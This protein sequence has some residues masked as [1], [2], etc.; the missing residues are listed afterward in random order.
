MGEKVRQPWLRDV[1]ANAHFQR[2]VASCSRTNQWE[3]R[4]TLTLKKGKFRFLVSL[5]SRSATSVSVFFFSKSVRCLGKDRSLFSGDQWSARTKHNPTEAG[6]RTV[7]RTKIKKHL[8]QGTSFAI[9]KQ[10]FG[11]KFKNPKSFMLSKNSLILTF[12]YW[13][14]QLLFCNWFLNHLLPHT[15]EWYK[16][17]SQ[18]CFLSNYNNFIVY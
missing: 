3:A 7:N 5:L 2:G 17:R 4:V 14:S 1:T 15:L 13:N 6:I 8:N 12:F 11:K 9:Q 18:V 16:W 10:L